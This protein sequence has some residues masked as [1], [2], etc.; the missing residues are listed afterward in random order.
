MSEVLDGSRQQHIHYIPT[1]TFGHDTVPVPYLYT[2]KAEPHEYLIGSHYSNPLDKS[3]TPVNLRFR[4]K[5]TSATTRYVR[6]GLYSMDGVKL[7]RFYGP[8]EYSSPFTWYEIP[9]VESIPNCIEPY[10]DYWRVIQI[11]LSR[12]YFNYDETPDPNRGGR[13]LCDF[14]YDSIPDVFTH[15]IDDRKFVIN[16]T[17]KDD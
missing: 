9:E 5:M 17:Y 7:A 12:L 15:E 2:D 10:G 4:G 8:V 11:N 13:M 1:I 14:D 6:G 3:G 16:C